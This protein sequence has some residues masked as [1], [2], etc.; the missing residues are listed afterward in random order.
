ML[1]VGIVLLALLFLPGIAL[2]AQ[3]A[4]T[5]KSGNAGIDGF[6]V[7]TNAVD[8][9]FTIPNL[10]FGFDLSSS[11]YNQEVL[12]LGAKYR[13]RIY[14][15]YAPYLVFN[16]L[17]IRPEYRH[18]YRHTQL[19]SRV[20]KDTLGRDSIVW[21]KAPLTSTKRKHPRPWQAWY[22][23][24]YADY[25]DY[26]LKFGEYGRQG[27]AVGAGVTIGFEI[28]LYEYKSGAIDLD[29]GLSAGLIATGNQAFKN[30][31]DIYR[32]V[33]V[34]AADKAKD[35]PFMV[36][37]MLTEVRATF[38][39]RH[40]SV[41]NK[42]LEPDPVL[43][44]YEQARK[45]IQDDMQSSTRQEFNSI[46]MMTAKDS[47]RFQKDEALYK[48]EYQKYLADAVEADERNIRENDKITS[49]MKTKLNRYLQSEKMKNLRQFDREVQQERIARE[50]ARKQAIRDSIAAVQQ[51]RRDSIAAVRKAY[52]DSVEAVKQA[53]RD[54][55]AAAKRALQA[56][57]DSAE[58]VKLMILQEPVVEPVIDTD[59]FPLELPLEDE[60]LMVAPFVYSPPAPEPEPEPAPEPEPT[61]EPAPEPAPAPEPEPT[62]EP[63]PA[64]AP[65]EPAPAPEP[66]K[67]ENV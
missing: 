65:A 29:L 55:I 41:R 44:Y 52:R 39:W 45:K 48:E 60:V 22:I 20:E 66:Q 13:P 12:L 5:G 36:I 51:A 37:P 43:A 54:S 19:G 59:P 6:T 40:K 27:W 49:S 57:K 42:Y 21:E 18:Y 17:D 2:S 61:P 28:P 53:R 7:K 47:L 62:P 32:Y 67:E 11:Q 10:Q 50:E 38:S 3:I 63:A 14:H 35:V 23:G 8:W 34:T 56:R 46:F 58:L 4:P 31:D 30:G 16:V 33:P 64:P 25:A 1:G 15:N 9:I 26:C 24:A